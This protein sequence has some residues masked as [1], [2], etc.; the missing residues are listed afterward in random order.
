MNTSALLSPR[1]AKERSKGIV[2][3]ETGLR[4]YYIWWFYKAAI[5]ESPAKAENHGFMIFAEGII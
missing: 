4:K 5:Q 1:I 2:A 3:Y